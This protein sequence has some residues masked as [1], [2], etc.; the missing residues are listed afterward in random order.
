MIAKDLN[1]KWS[2]VSTGKLYLSG[3]V[4]VVI[5]VHNIQIGEAWW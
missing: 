5:K 1:Y 2:L 4:C 3:M